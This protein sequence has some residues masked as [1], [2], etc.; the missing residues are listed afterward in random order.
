MMQLSDLLITPTP[1]GSLFVFLIGLMVGSF[2]NVC[3]VRFPKDESV[4]RGRSRCPCCGHQIAWYDNI[5]ILSILFLG[6]KCRH[7]RGPI[8]LRY[9]LVEFLTGISFLGAYHLWGWTGEFACYLYL[10][11][12]L[13]VVTFVDF[14]H[15]I[16]PDEVSLMGI[17]A[18]LAA[19][20]LFPILQGEVDHRLGLAEA[21][22][23]MLAGVGLIYAVAILGEFLFKKE[24]MGG[25]D[26]KLLAMIGA[27]LGW[28]KTVLTF[29]IAPLLG[30]PVGL[31]IWKVTK[32]RYIAFGPYL[33]MASMI[34]LLFGEKI[35][36]WYFP[37]GWGI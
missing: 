10:I 32:N 15:Q 22:L 7:C 34:A 4:A 3:I 20:Y 9:P 28:E 30:A 33:A 35:I 23:G 31:I 5:P 17:L 16:I 29:L 12:S 21:S 13:I 11:S 25:G 36:A 37:F 6:G 27:F 24:S 8:S 18:G 2:L 1:A 26:L 19:S 14:E